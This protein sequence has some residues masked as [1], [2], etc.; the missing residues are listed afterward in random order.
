MNPKADAR[1]RW[2]WM[3]FD[4]AA[5]PWNT[6]VI[7]FI[8]GPY[9]V[10]TVA[11]DPVTGQTIWAWATGA[12]GLAIA[13]AAPVLGAAA[14][15]TGPRKP[16]IA[17]FGV[18]YVA[19]ALGLWWAAPNAGAVPI[20][21]AAFI[22]GLIGSEF[23]AVF[24]NA[25]L[26]D[27]VER[28]GMGRLSGNGW[29]M[30]YAGGVASLIIMLALFAENAQGTTLIGIVPILGL[31][32]AAREGTRFV[33]PVT[34]AWFVV[35]AAPLFLYV[36]DAPRRGSARG[37][38]A[39]GLAELRGSLGDMRQR[40][41]LSWFLGASMI[42]RDG[43]NGFYAFGGIYAAGVLGWSIVQIGVFGILAAAIGA[44]GAWIGG[45]ADDAFGPK[46]VVAACLWGLAAASLLGVSVSREAV[47]FL[48][49]VAADSA[50][51]DIGFYIAGALVGAFGGSLQ[52]SS[53][54]LL[55]RQAD[56][57]RMTAAF[58]LYALA[59]KATAFLAPL[60]IAAATA[61]SGSQQWGVAPIIALFL[62]GLAALI[63]VSPE[64][65]AAMERSAA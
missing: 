29:A 26:P 30:G 53:R 3:I 49:P 62:L 27:L 17:A 41:S 20:A 4:W 24:A 35:F 12:A 40:P 38:V 64:G 13:L 39:R 34:A 14:D 65:D 22:V 1:A 9:F 31:D 58:G 43:L 55:V 63:P 15:A 7:T 42:Y 6:L 48:V 44:L 56:E 52:A 19:G 45:R 33:G 23:A 61:L 36:P 50:L 60:L 10:S 25:M 37:A 11:P 18:F 57:A 47:L 54:T 21:V 28:E 32:A 59:G 51:P 8:F 46:R 2:S 5:Q 16:W